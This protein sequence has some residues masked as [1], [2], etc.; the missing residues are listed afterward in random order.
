MV[1]IMEKI[2]LNKNVAKYKDSRTGLWGLVNSNDEIIVK[3][4]YQEMV[5]VLNQRLSQMMASHGY[6][7]DYINK[8]LWQLVE[9]KIINK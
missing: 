3:A 4:K 5:V 7:Q 1:K 6:S 8:N 2:F 9:I